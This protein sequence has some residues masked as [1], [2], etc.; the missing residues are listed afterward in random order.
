ME[1]FFSK[2]VILDAMTETHAWLTLR[3]SDYDSEDAPQQAFLA[4]FQEYL[5]QHHAWVLREGL[6]RFAHRNGLACFTLDAQHNHKGEP[7]YP[8]EIFRW[9]AE[10]S[11]GSYGLLYFQDDEDPAHDNEFQVYVLKRGKLIKAQDPFLSPCIEEIEREYDE[12]DP[13]RD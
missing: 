7:F 2:A 13:P 6:V 5:R 12:N 3:Y 8:L 9:A 1:T 4:A 10:H 11:T